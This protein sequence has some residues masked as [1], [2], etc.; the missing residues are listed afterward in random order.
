MCK[1]TEIGESLLPFVKHLCFGIHEMIIF[2][3]SNVGNNR[4]GLWA[5]LKPQGSRQMRALLYCL[6]RLFCSLGVSLKVLT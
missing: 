3:F 4:S 6:K 1:K 2:C 5:A